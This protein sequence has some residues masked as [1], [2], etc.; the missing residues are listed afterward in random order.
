[1]GDREVPWEGSLS[2]LL[3]NGIDGTDELPSARPGPPAARAVPV[4]RTGVA[5]RCVLRPAEI[6]AALLSPVRPADEAARFGAAPATRPRT[7]GSV[8]PT[9][10]GSTPAHHLDRMHNA[11]RKPI[12]PGRRG[13]VVWSSENRRRLGKITRPEKEKGLWT[14]G[15]GLA[16]TGPGILRLTHTPHLRRPLPR[17]PL[18][19]PIQAP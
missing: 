14:P 13:S 5:G 4:R 19:D 18:P 3:L 2:Q 11:P 7:A 15:A 9:P 6:V 17:F 12:T 8:G 1:V 16:I 10:A